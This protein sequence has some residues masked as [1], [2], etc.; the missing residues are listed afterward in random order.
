MTRPG[1]PSTLRITGG[2]LG[3]RRIQSPVDGSIRPTA[4]KV[5]QAIFNILNARGLVQDAVV[6]DA[7]CGTG[8]M[9]IEALSHG[10]RRAVFLDAS[11]EAVR[12]C[13]RNLDSLG[14]A[15]RASVRQGDATRPGPCPPGFS[16]ATLVFLD[17]PYDK[18]LIL[19]SI[20]ALVPRGWIASGATLVLEASR[21]ENMPFDSIINCFERGKM[22][23]KIE[24]RYGDTQVIVL[25]LHA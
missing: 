6:L 13:A 16:P 9:G 4:D 24:K 3:S 15:D 11:A 8:A 22:D 1:R 10:A 14:L 2:V 25:T 5:R 21:D 23:L 12:L 19:Q 20:E 7:F 17:P 18:G